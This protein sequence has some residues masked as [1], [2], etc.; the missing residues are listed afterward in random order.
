MKQCDLCNIVGTEETELITN[1]F[2]KILNEE[3]E[4]C[5]LCKSFVLHVI[6]QREEE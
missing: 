4:I 3:Y 5:Y 2:I 6:K 1:I